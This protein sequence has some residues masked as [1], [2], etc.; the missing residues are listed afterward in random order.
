MVPQRQIYAE[1]S[2]GDTVSATTIHVDAEANR[3]RVGASG[4][5]W[6]PGRARAATLR[7]SFACCSN[8]EPLMGGD[9][10]PSWR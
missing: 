7:A 4:R 6:R 10:H 8:D 2:L 3:H 5:S 1:A 9:G